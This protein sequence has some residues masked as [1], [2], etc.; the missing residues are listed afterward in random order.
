[1]K[2]L[3]VLLV[4][5]GLAYAQH[6]SAEMGYEPMPEVL[7]RVTLDDLKYVFN[8]ITPAV[9]QRLNFILN[10]LGL[11]LNDLEEA[12]DN[13]PDIIQQMFGST[14]M[15]INDVKSIVGNMPE[16]IKQLLESV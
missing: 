12:L 10:L 13:P 14:G 11:S 2:F 16:P 3:I 1:M 9:K 6:S 15:S 4:L 7:Q 5:V 8:S